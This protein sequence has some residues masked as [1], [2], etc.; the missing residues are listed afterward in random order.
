MTAPIVPEDDEERDFILQALRYY[1]DSCQPSVLHADCPYAVETAEPGVRGCGDECLTIRA[2]FGAPSGPIGRVVPIDN[3]VE[4]RLLAP[5]KYRRGP[6]LSSKP[7][8][9]REAYLEDKALPVGSSWRMPSLL[10]GLISELGVP[11]VSRSDQALAERGRRL[12][13]IMEELQKRSVD[14][15][16]LIRGGLVNH[17]GA[18]LLVGIT[19][20]LIVGITTDAGDLQDDEGFVAM[21]S[22]PTL[23]QW[24]RLVYGDE[25]S[26]LERVEK[27]QRRGRP[28]VHQKQRKAVQHLGTFA[29]WIE[30][31]DIDSILNRTPPSHYEFQLLTREP[32]SSTDPHQTWLVDR[33]VLTYPQTWRRSSLLLEWR[34]LHG[35]QLPPCDQEVMNSRRID[36]LQ[37][38]EAIANMAA[39]E[40]EVDQAASV[41]SDQY[42][43]LAARMLEEGRRSAAAGVFEAQRT[44]S[45]GD[46]TAHN[47]HGF[48]LLIDEPEEGLLSLERAASLG[49]GNDA[50]NVANRMFGLRA[51]NRRASALGLAERYWSTREPDADR[52]PAYL[53]DI[54]APGQLLTAADPHAYIAELALAVVAGSGDI[55]DEATWRHRLDEALQGR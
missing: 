53:W 17:I 40:A 16:T 5:R 1:S 42:V 24:A 38:A 6:A 34:Y 27:A 25:L 49:L 36:R 32:H 9:A 13:S 3:E 33:F 23:D 54:R 19:A 37:L 26:V 46:A 50:V 4:V 8:D 44:V 31:A 43:H 47:H 7:F 51:L 15:E 12:T 21:L 11:A 48:C 29:R 30:T 18:S 52:A 22:E 55:G 39:G 2:K 45:P 20:P 10:F 35:E 28:W 41:S 14:V